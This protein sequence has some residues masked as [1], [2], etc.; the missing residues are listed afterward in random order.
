MVRSSPNGV[1]AMSDAFRCD[2]CEEFFQGDPVVLGLEQF[3]TSGAVPGLVGKKIHRYDL[4]ESCAEA[5]E[6][7]VVNFVEGDRDG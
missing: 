6:R 7:T 1:I 4:C 5:L 2:K 3:P